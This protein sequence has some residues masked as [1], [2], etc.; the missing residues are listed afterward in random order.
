LVIVS[1]Y[2]RRIGIPAMLANRF[3]FLRKSSKGTKLISI[4]HMFFIYRLE[5]DKPQRIILG[6]DTMVMDNN[7]AD[8]RELEIGFIIGGR[9]YV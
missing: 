3:F 4:F 9:M 6:L 8:K 5:K 7:D 2:L 1:R